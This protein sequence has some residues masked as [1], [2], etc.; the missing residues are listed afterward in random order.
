MAVSATVTAG[1]QEGRLGERDEDPVAAYL[2][3]K[4]MLRLEDYLKRGRHLSGVDSGEL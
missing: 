1:K 3:N 4:E 2:A